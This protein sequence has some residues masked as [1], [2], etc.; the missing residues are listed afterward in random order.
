MRGLK[1]RATSNR[2]FSEENEIV[3]APSIEKYQA[4]SGRRNKY[5]D[6]F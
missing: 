5:I 6:R 4:I 3:F 2:F 1:L